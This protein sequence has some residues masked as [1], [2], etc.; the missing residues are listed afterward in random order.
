MYPEGMKPWYNADFRKFMQTIQDLRKV[1]GAL[2]AQRREECARNGDGGRTDALTMLVTDKGPDGTLFFHDELAVSTL[3]GFLNGAYDTTHATLD[4]VM[5]Q[6][7]RS[8]NDQRLLQV[9]GRQPPSS[10]GEGSLV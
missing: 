5:Y 4:W 3:I 1:A 6:L 8:T 2:V 9:T 7:A 10:G